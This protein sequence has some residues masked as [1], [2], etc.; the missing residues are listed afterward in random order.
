MNLL[1]KLKLFVLY[2]DSLSLRKNEIT[3]LEREV[4]AFITLAEVFTHTTSKAV[5]ETLFARVHCWI[6]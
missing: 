5:R 3:F 4:S 2:L 6:L 1:M